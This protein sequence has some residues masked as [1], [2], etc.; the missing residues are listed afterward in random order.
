MA[1]D[2]HE[3]REVLTGIHDA[4]IT[5]S[6]IEKYSTECEEFVAVMAR[7]F[8]YFRGLDSSLSKTEYGAYLAGVAY[9]A[10][11]NHVL[12]LRLILLGLVVPAGNMQRY[13]LECIALALLG[14]DRGLP[15]FQ[16]YINNKY[17]TSKAI[18]HVIKHHKRLTLNK[19]ALEKL[20][21]ASRFYDKYSHPTPLT[22]A[23]TMSPGEDGPCIVLGGIYDESK[24]PA[25]KKEIE[26]RLGLA[27]TFVNFLEGIERN[28][29]K[30]N[31]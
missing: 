31:A 28:V 25:Y 29:G 17:S 2:E 18:K 23:T 30:W 20:K 3:I 6:F 24:E 16:E 5:S 7:A 21:C 11:S 12:S 13:V 8:Q 26:S 1:F 19:C 14:S 4:S 22:L 15:M 10:L 9:A 27:N